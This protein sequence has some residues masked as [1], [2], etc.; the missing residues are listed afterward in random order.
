MDA[1]NAYDSSDE[2]ENS[3]SEGLQRQSEAPVVDHAESSN[4]LSKLKERFPLDSAPNVPSR[5]RTF[6]V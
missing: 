3:A 1:I 5:V 4:V 6:R 2:E